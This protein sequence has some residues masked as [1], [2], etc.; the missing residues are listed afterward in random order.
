MQF[1]K[2]VSQ[3]EIFH[4][5]NDGGGS[6]GRALVIEI[7]AA[8]E[9]PTQFRDSSIIRLSGFDRIRDDINGDGEKVKDA[10]Q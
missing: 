6:F 1:I 3:R 8:G 4:L 9:M 7:Q 10:A 5:K 2:G